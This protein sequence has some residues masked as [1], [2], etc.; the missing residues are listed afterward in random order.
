MET[1]QRY[2][3]SRSGANILAGIICVILGLVLGMRLSRRAVE[4]SPV[5]VVD[6][7]EVVRV[8]TIVVEKPVLVRRVRKDTV[9][10]ALRDTVRVRDT[11]YVAV[12]REELLYEDREYRAQVSGYNAGLDWIEIYPRTVTRTVYETIEGRD[13]RRWG[14]GVQ[15]G[16]GLTEGGFVPYVGVGLSYNLIRF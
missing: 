1:L 2:T 11:T 12:E 5:K 15:V 7:L 6:T 3:M 14:I 13:R 10:I 16:Y 9:L 4:V 8:D